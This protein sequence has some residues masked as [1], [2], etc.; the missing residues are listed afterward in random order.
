[1]E[2]KCYKNFFGCIFWATILFKWYQ[3]APGCSTAISHNYIWAPT[4]MLSFSEEL[5]SQFQENLQ[6]DERMDRQDGHRTLPAMDRGPKIDN[7]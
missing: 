5:I 2:K 3:K 7:K 4:T 1:M 6:T